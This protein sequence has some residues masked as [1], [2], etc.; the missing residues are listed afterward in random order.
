MIYK[1]SVDKQAICVGGFKSEIKDQFSSQNAKGTLYMFRIHGATDEG[2]V[3]GNPI[4]GK[5]HTVSVTDIL[6]IKEVDGGVVTMDSFDNLKP[7]DVASALFAGE[8]VAAFDSN[9]VEVTI[10]GFSVANKV[11]SYNL[12]AGAVVGAADL[13][14]KKGS[15]AFGK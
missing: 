8:N 13:F 10:T 1:L 6:K 2:I 12:E 14:I 5:E 7:Y 3:L 15:V 4:T 11:V 9:F